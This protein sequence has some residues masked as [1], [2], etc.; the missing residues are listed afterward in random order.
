[1]VQQKFFLKN[2]ILIQMIIPFFTRMFENR[3]EAS[4]SAYLAVAL[5]ADICPYTKVGI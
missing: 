2:N 4:G 3:I 1:M 5:F